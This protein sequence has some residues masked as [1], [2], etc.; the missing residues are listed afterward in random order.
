[1][2]YINS[3]EKSWECLNFIHNSGVFPVTGK[4]GGKPA[5]DSFQKMTRWVPK[6]IPLIGGKGA[7]PRIPP[8]L[9][10]YVNFPQAGIDA[11]LQMYGQEIR[12][13]EEGERIYPNEDDIDNPLTDEIN[14]QL[15][16]DEPD[17]I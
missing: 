1:M 7:I 11:F 14:I 17:K 12:D 2:Y 8:E 9:L 3:M 16:L 13:L 10:E 5:P 6:P 15:I 4:V